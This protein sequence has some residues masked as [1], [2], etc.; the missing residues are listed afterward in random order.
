VN[1][2]FVVHED[3]RPLIAREDS[4][5]KRDPRIG[6]LGELPTIFDTYGMA[7]QSVYRLPTG[8]DKMKIMQL[9]A[10]QAEPVTDKLYH[11]ALVVDGIQM[12]MTRSIEILA[13]NEDEARANILS[14]AKWEINLQ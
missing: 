6:S 7:R 12:Q 10:L 13:R 11:A 9:K 4:S 1:K 5:F 8:K 14:R 3:G 2:F